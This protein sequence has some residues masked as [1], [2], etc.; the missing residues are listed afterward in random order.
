MSATLQLIEVTLHCTEGSA[1]KAYRVQTIEAPDGTFGV[2]ADSARIG[3][4]W[5][6]QGWKV[7]GVTEEKARKQAES[8]IKAKTAK[9]YRL[10]DSTSGGEAPQLVVAPT[11]TP[12]HRPMLLNPIDLAEAPAYLNDGA[13]VMEEKKDGVR[14]MLEREGEKV[15]GFNKRGVEVPV[16]AS[17][18]RVAIS[19]PA[20]F[21]LDGELVGTTLWAF[22]ILE[23]DGENLRD[24]GYLERRDWLSKLLRFAR[25]KSPIA[26]VPFWAY[27]QKAKM[28]E[29]LRENRAEGVVFK[30]SRAPYACGRP[31]SGGD[32]IKCKFTETA[33]FLVVGTNGKRSVQ[34]GVVPAPSD[35]PRAAGL[36]AKFQ[37]EPG[38]PI[39]VG[40]VTIPANHKIPPIGAI[41]EVRYLYAYPNGS[42]F[43][44]TYLGERGDVAE[45]ECHAGQLKF[46]QT[47][48]DDE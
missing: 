37:A 12:V 32:A 14:F 34:V 16:E 21:L 46:R 48:E 22:D 44:A 4:A 3:N 40:N 28:L 15:R 8:L 17:L 43:Q 2:R 10:V 1:S 20:D 9:G 31:A 30:R 26:E 19:L 25:A 41:V 24:R 23:A 45:A 13:W 11:A 42:I 38:V 39:G 29:Q 33:S 27:E 6:D 47:A 7:Q 35:H 5:N 18:V 36:P